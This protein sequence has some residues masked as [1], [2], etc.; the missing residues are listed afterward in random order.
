MNKYT[1][2]N[3]RNICDILTLKAP[4]TTAADDKFW[5]IFPNFRKKKIW[6]FVRIVCQQTILIV[7]HAFFVILKKQQKFKLSS[8]AKY[9]WRFMG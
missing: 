5:D 9:R 6:Y 8:A 4:I 1:E 7:Y 2:I 3:K